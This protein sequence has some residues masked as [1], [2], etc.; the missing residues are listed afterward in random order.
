MQMKKYRILEICGH[1]YPQESRFFWW[2]YLD[3]EFPNF[4]WCK[5]NMD[6][7]ECHSLLEAKNA[8]RKRKLYLKLKTKKPII[9]NEKN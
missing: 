1:F 6:Q 4:T 7:S 2:K 3:N 5:G 8:I 9:H